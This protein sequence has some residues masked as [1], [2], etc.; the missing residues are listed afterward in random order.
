MYTNYSILV[1]FKWH[2]SSSL[3]IGENLWQKMFCRKLVL[4]S[5]SWPAPP[6]CSLSSVEEQPS[7]SPLSRCSSRSSPESQPTWPGEEKS[8]PS[9]T[10]SPQICQR[11]A[12]C[13]RRLVCP[14]PWSCTWTGSPPSSSRWPRLCPH[15]RCNSLSKSPWNMLAFHLAFVLELNESRILAEAAPMLATVSS[16]LNWSA[17][18]G[19]RE[20]PKRF[21]FVSV[22]VGT[23]LMRAPAWI[24]RATQS[25]P[26]RLSSAGST[27]G[28]SGCTPRPPACSGRSR[29]APG[30]FPDHPRLGWN[31]C[32]CSC[33][34]FWSARSCC[35]FAEER[36]TVRCGAVS[37]GREGGGSW[38]GMLEQRPSVGAAR[39]GGQSLYLSFLSC[40]Q[41][42]E[43]GWTGWPGGSL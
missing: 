41:T 22:E 2:H 1:G 4:G 8:W 28:F 13:P 35:C 23:G 40:H 10:W 16:M 15:W 36:V 26:T 32:R 18:C 17:F 20:K 29:V 3:F 43:S 30:S 19:G 5:C 39:K 27:S 11:E 12:P 7:P 34:E 25:S 21:C 31:H 6:L 33:C 14:P 24:L 38:R 37:P 42:W 9:A